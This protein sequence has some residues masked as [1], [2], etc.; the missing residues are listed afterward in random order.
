MPVSRQQSR[1]ELA[2]KLDQE[3]NNFSASI[4]MGVLVNGACSSLYMH[5]LQ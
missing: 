2:Q 3:A 4:H 5:I 1:F